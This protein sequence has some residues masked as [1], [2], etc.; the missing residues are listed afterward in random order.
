ML[1]LLPKILFAV[2]LLSAVAIAHAAE[3]GKVDTEV[4]AM[5]AE[6]I[7]APVLAKDGTEVGEVA[8]IS[9]DE[10]A[11]PHRLRITTGA[12]LGLGTRTLEIPKGAFMPVRGAVILHVPAE[13]ISAFAELAEPKEK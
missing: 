8:D 5:V 11:Q 13:A 2:L 12:A 3:P 6:L 4:A 9:F 7:G 10:Q 1:T